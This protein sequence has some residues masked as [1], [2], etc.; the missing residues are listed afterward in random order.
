MAFQRNFPIHTSHFCGFPPPPPA[1]TGSLR[2]MSSSALTWFGSRLSNSCYTFHHKI[3]SSHKVR[4]PRG[5]SMSPD[6]A[7][8]MSAFSTSIKCILKPIFKFLYLPLYISGI[9]MLMGPN[10]DT[11]TFYCFA[12]STWSA[13]DA[14][15][16]PTPCTQLFLQVSVKR[17]TIIL[18]IFMVIYA[19]KSTM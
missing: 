6:H 8:T 2:A 18:R 11:T 3:A 19:I 14:P 17:V 4:N 1:F 15:E 13:M 9:L 10:T 5:G 7:F 16:S 12:G